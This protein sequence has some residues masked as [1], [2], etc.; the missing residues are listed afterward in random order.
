M[1]ITLEDGRNVLADA[2]TKTRTLLER[3]QLSE[4]LK[5]LLSLVGRHASTRIRHGESNLTRILRQ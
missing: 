4:T 3:I 1:D 2:K 5:D